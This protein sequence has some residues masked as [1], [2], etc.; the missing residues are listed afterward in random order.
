[1]WWDFKTLEIILDN[2]SN[3]PL[4]LPPSGTCLLPKCLTF[5]TNIYTNIS[6]VAIMLTVTIFATIV[7]DMLPVSNNT[8]LIGQHLA[9]NLTVVVPN[10]SLPSAN[11]CTTPATKMCKFWNTWSLCLPCMSIVTEES[12]CLLKIIF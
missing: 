6:G 4:W 2:C 9:N 12:I 1:M 3:C 5:V 7:A 11:I 8:P 10:P